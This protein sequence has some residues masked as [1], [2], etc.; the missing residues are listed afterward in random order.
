M[1]GAAEGTDEGICYN[2]TTRKVGKIR[3]YL[4][5]YSIVKEVAICKVELPE[6]QLK[7]QQSVFNLYGKGLFVWDD[8]ILVTKLIIG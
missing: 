5:L 1:V 4:R 2:T 8:I 3:K 7:L 6:I